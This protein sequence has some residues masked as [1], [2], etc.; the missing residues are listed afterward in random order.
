LN[1]QAKISKTIIITGIETIT[2]IE[3]EDYATPKNSPIEL[4][5]GYSMFKIE[6]IVISIIPSIITLKMKLKYNPLLTI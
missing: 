4:Y 6:Y 3:K 2:K 5:I 1:F